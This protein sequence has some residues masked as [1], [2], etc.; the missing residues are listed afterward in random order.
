MKM[1]PW[2]ISVTLICILLGLF[3]VVQF[4]TQSQKSRLS[5]ARSEAL[6]GFYEEAEAKRKRLQDQVAQLREEL[7]KAAEVRNVQSGLAAEVQKE[8]VKAGLTE[9]EGPG[10]V[11]TLN[12]S[13]R[14]PRPGQ[15]ED[16]YLIH[17]EDLLLV[18]NELLAGGAEGI[19]LNG[20]RYTSRSEIRCAG[21]TASINQTRVGAPFV[22]QAVGDPATLESS[23][24]LRGGVIDA[25]RTWGIQ[26]R[27]ERSDRLLLPAYA[28]SLQFD[29]AKPAR[30]RK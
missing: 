23:I 28:G 9:I 1:R 26:V 5:T 25:L 2:Q 15:S 24:R 12:D 17:D 16:L 7:G 19:A 27:I 10:V 6:V 29:Y 14:E 8:R 20:Q 11:V 4:R 22:I 3:V 18:I 13:S 21:P 30:G